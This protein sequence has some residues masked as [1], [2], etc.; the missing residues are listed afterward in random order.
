MEAKGVS[1]EIS[2]HRALLVERTEYR[3]FL[4]KHDIE[5]VGHLSSSEYLREVGDI[6]GALVYL[7][8]ALSGDGYTS[9]YS[10]A[11]NAPRAA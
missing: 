9:G 5:A 6:K 1:G 11:A 4:T 10:L 7:A 3:L 2:R 8:A